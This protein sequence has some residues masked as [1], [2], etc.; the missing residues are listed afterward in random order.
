VTVSGFLE[1]DAFCIV[2]TLPNAVIE[3][4]IRVGGVSLVVVQSAPAMLGSKVWFWG[5]AEAVAGS[6]P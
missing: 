1:S 2:L 5:L 6:S 4:G 3:G